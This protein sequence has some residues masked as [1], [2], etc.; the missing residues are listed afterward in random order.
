MRLILFLSFLVSSFLSWGEC[1]DINI[2]AE[3]KQSLNSTAESNYIVK[4][5][6]RVYFYSA[7]D[8]MCRIKNIFIIKNDVVSVYAEYK[9]FSSVM[10][11]RKNGD[12]V[13][14]W[15]HSDSIEPIGTGVGPKE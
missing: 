3:Q 8:E 7:P 9:G 4:Y 5:K 15:I 14:G 2:S 13:S 6:S 11:F 10:F 1:S 12:P